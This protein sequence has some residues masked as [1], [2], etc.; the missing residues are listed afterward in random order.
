MWMLQQKYAKD[1]NLAVAHSDNN[2]L[3]FFNVG[4]GVRFSVTEEGIEKVIFEG[5]NGE[6]L[7]GK[8]KIGF[9]NG[10]PKVQEVTSGSIFLTLLPPDGETFQK[11]KWYFIVALPGAL[12]KGY[13]MRFYKGDDYARRISESPVTIKRSIYGTVEKAD[14][15]IELEGDREGVRREGERGQGRGCERGVGT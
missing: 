11:D 5:L 2:T 7:A 13:K 10:I 1:M 9:E 14:D 8:V 12:E 6:V 3:Q 4:G 15:G